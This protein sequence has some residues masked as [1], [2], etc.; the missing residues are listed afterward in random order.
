MEK[1]ATKNLHV[2]YVEDDD[3][4]RE[5]GIE[6]LENYFDHVHAASDAFEG[7]K[8]YREVHPEIII[9]DIQMPKL[10]GLEFIKQIRKENKETQI[11]VIS[12]YSDTTYL[13]QAIEL[14][15]VKYL[16]KPVQESAF[17][18]ALRQCI[19]SIHHKDSNIINLPENTYFDTYNQ[20]LVRDGDIVALRTKELQILSLLLKYKNRY[21]T[22][23]EIENHVW[24]ES[25]M[26]NDAL[27]TLMKNLKAK[28][29]PNLISN[30]SGT[31][32]KIE[33]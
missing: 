28:L 1:S 32:Y 13:L 22:Y 4:A 18:E 7:L 24:R 14:Q 19:E 8:L 11:I 25:A 29:P 3:V 23:S 10:N 21:V 12:A 26:S 15:L 6:Y 9:T 30:L 5:N 27:K 20:T 33:C 16:I 31:G 17:K 2:L